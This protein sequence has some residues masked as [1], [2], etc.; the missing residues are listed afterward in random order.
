MLMVDRSR[1]R[2]GSRLLLILV[3]WDRSENEDIG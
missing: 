1:L 3:L 2:F